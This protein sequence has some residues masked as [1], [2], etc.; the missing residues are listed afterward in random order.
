[1][2]K[3]LPQQQ[4]Q[5]AALDRQLGKP[6]G[7]VQKRS[8]IQYRY[9]AAPYDSQAELGAKALGQALE[10]A[11]L[12]SDAIDLLI[13]ASAIPVQALPCTATYILRASGCSEGT[14]GFDVNLSCAGFVAALQ[15]AAGLLQTQAYKRIAIV[16]SE[17]A[18]RGLNWHDEESSYL[19]GDGAACAIVERGNGSTGILGACLENHIQDGDFCQIRAGGTRCN[20]VAGMQESDF[21]FQM[22]GDKVFKLAA[23]HLQ[24]F[25]NRLL[26]TAGLLL[27]DIDLVIPH[28]AS[29]LGIEH[30]RR[31]LGIDVQK[32]MNIYPTHGNQVA[33][34]IPTAMYE[35]ISQGRCKAGDKVMLIATAAS[36]SLAGMVLVL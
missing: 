28:Q 6:Q 19:F 36:I 2:G 29:H 35:A 1:M 16:C 7:Y 25:Q 9:L 30:M 34:S 26:T 18:S 5:S 10:N 13:S 12:Q 4:V 24:P 20:P 14:P 17:L 27:D 23:K 15:V 31:K 21:Y 8:G 32:L 11:G 3:A 22:Q 33:A